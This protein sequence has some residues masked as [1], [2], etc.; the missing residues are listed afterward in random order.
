MLV[1]G[2]VLGIAAGLLAGGDLR[3]LALFEL[4]WWPLLLVGLGL[5]VVAGFLPLPW[6]AY[7]AAFAAVL[8]VALANAALPGMRLIATGAALNL[9]VVAA[10]GAMPVDQRALDAAAASMPGDQLHVLLGPD[11]RLA[12]LADVI[13]VPILRAVYSVGDVFLA[14]GAF[15]L[16]F[17]WLRRR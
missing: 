13:P 17:Q 9:S 12:L 16:P 1:S 14:A 7:V 3:R 2:L 11:A 10:N 15:W 8:A 6:L 5:R 4:R